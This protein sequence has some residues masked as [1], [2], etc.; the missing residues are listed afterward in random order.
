MLRDLQSSLVNQLIVVP[1][2]IT[3]AS[4]TSIKATT[5]V[6][7]CS[8]CG[9]EKQLKVSL[10]YSRV[11]IPRSCDNMRNPGAERQQCKLD[12]YQIVTEKCEYVDQQ[13]LK[14]QEAPELIPTGE[15]PRTF[16]MTVD[17]YLADKVTPGNRVKVVGVLSILNRMEG[18]AGG[19]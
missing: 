9:H 8:N 7:R 3:S 10:G 5:V 18:G 6:V 19:E 11:V 15:M 1:G 17:R 14:L 4:K 12:S 16:G 13:Y 2:I